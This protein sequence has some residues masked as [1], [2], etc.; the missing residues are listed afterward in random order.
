MFLGFSEKTQD[1]LW[2]VR[3][4]N[5]RPWFEAHKQD[6]LDHVQTPLRALGEEV[7]EKFTAAHEELPLMLRIS[8]IYRDAR[9]LYGRGPYKSN[10][11]FTL[12]MAGEDWTHMP[13][14]WFEIYPKGYAYGLGAYDAKP[15]QMAKFRQAV[16]TDP[17]PMLKLA[18]AFARQD[19]FALQAE[20]YK[21]P[22]GNPQPPLD[23]WY[24]RKNLDITCSRPVE[25]LLYSP[26]LVDVLVEGY[27]SLMPYYHYFSKIF[28]Q[29]D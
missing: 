22:K 3:L 17:K 21:R 28:R 19:R 24:N 13:V 26:E 12:R 4:N 15:A 7:Y 9:R 27:E 16:D 1:F 23:Q 6:Y 2:G 20:E 25:P 11:W 29:G 10:L 8:R 14:F 5:E 18:R